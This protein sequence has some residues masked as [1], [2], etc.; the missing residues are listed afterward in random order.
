MK[1][2]KVQLVLL[3]LS[4]VCHGQT[5]FHSVI[6]SST[7]A[8]MGASVTDSCWVNRLTHYYQQQGLTIIP[9]NLAVP[10]RNCYHGMPSSYM[11]PP[12][13]DFPQPGENVTM[14]MTF[15]P[16]VVIVSYPTNNYNFYS[17]AEI[18]TCLQ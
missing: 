18:M 3:F 4:V 16:D 8:G 10:G 7:A 15:N 6:G 17:T 13:R 2:S 9:H 5:K 1:K 14:A 12:S 11:P